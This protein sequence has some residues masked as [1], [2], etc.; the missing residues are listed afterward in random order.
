MLFQP[1]LELRHNSNT[2]TLP[3]TLSKPLHTLNKPLHTL[4]K[5][6]HTLSEPLHTLSEP[7][8]T[9][10]VPLHT[11]SVPLHTLNKPLHT[12]SEPLHTLSEPLH[13]KLTC[14][15]Q[16]LALGLIG[17]PPPALYIGSE[18]PLVQQEAFCSL[19]HCFRMA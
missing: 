3:Y 19:S 8:H 14:L 17:S 15:R 5:P 7:L 1:A 9:L 10:S 12:L 2:H 16:P 4:S 13:T 11:L 18:C 6:L